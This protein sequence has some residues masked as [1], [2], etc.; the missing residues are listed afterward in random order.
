MIAP[1]TTNGGTTPYPSFSNYLNYLQTGGTG[2]TPIPT[3]IAG[4]N[5]QFSKGGPFQNYN[6]NA[7]ISNSTQTINGMTIH[8]GDLVMN[9]TVTNAS[10]PPSPLTIVV[11]KANLSS[12]AIYGANPAYTICTDCS[13]PN[14]VVEKAVADYFSGLNFGFIGSAA[15]NPNAPGQTI[16]ASP[17]WTWYGNQPNGGGPAP[18]PLSDAYAAAQ[19]GEPGFYN[20][21]A[22]YLNNSSAPVTDAYGF[23]YTD[24]LAS[25]LAP[26][27]DN[28]ILTMTILPDTAGSGSVVLGHHRPRPEYGD[29]RGLARRPHPVLDAHGHRRRNRDSVRGEHLFGRHDDHRR[30]DRPGHELESGDL[31]LDRH[32]RSSRSTTESCRPAPTISLSATPY[33]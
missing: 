25:P 16:G 1:S 19:P 30:H 2:S 6:L 32:R 17:S 20:A 27:D 3:T 14:K 8:P 4:Q 12:F 29:V 28:T 22:A 18:L 31:L 24:R 13:D 26:L 23:P 10:G 11:T 21:Y 9:G 15:P 5:G 7:V 33:R